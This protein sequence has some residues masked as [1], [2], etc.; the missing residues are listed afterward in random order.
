MATPQLALKNTLG[1]I[2]KATRC[3]ISVL[4]Y[5]EKC[6]IITDLDSVCMEPSLIAFTTN[7][8]LDIGGVCNL[9]ALND[10]AKHHLEN[11]SLKNLENHIGSVIKGEIILR[12][13]LAFSNFYM[14]LVNDVNIEKEG[15]PLIIS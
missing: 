13:D 15:L 2:M 4:N 3:S 5:Q 6:Q 8:H 12:H 11:L 10:T 9:Y 14:L 7:L 1:N